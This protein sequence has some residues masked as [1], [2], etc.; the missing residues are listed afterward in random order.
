MPPTK[1]KAAT[2][3][4]NVDKAIKQAIATIAPKS[5]FAAVA[6]KDYTSYR[7]SL[8]FHSW[9]MGGVPQK[10]GIIEG[11]LRKGI[12]IDSDEE[13]RQQALETLRQLFPDKVVP[14]MTYEEAVKVTEELAESHVNTFKRSNAGFLYVE[15]RQVKAMLKEALNIRYPKDRIGHGKGAK[16]FAE[17]RFF[18]PAESISLGVKE[19]S[20]RHLFVGHVTDQRGERSTLTYYDYVERPTISFNLIVQS[21]AVDVLEPMWPLI[22]VT[23]ENNGLGALRSQGFGTFSV[24]EW[25]KV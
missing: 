16:K 5:V 8:A 3:P 24:T 20:G 12:G 1:V 21:T 6:A 4:A 19:P 11:W 7:V 2:K 9:I 25:T 13:L 14:G 18:I 22:W 17:E 23:A 15:G 10:I